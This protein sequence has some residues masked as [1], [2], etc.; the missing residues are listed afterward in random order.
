MNALT[1]I[2]GP[3]RLI[4]YRTRGSKHG[5]ITRLVSPSDLELLRA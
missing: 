3:T 1:D 5:S 4:T 2:V